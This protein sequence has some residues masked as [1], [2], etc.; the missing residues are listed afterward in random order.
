MAKK[1]HKQGSARRAVQRSTPTPAAI[2]CKARDD[3]AQGRYRDAIAGLKQLLKL[4][5]RPAWRDALAEAYAGRARELADKGMLKESLVMWENRASLGEGISV[6]LDQIA[7]LMRLDQMEAALALYGEPDLSAAQ[8]DRLRPVLAARLLSGDETFARRL[9]ADD[10]VVLHAEAARSALT[11]YCGADDAA[12][13][14]AL[15]AIPFRSP[16]R[17]WAQILKALQRLP[18]RPDESRGLLARVADDSAFGALKRAAELALLPETDF[19]AAIRGAGEVTARFACILRG[20]PEQRIALG[21]ALDR[22][23]ANPSPDHLLHFMARQRAILG[24]DWARRRG[25]RLL[26]DGFPSSMRWLVSVGMGPASKEEEN[27][28][29]A[30]KSESRRELWQEVERWEA[31]ARGLMR[32][33]KAHPGDRKLRIALALRRADAQGDVLAR[34]TPSADADDLDRVVANQVAESLAWDPDDRDAHLRLIHY[35]RRG[36]QLKDARRI[37]DGARTLW[38]N[39]LRVLGASLDI[40]IDAGSFKKATALAREMLAQ[41][42][43]NSGVRERLVNAH[44]AHARKLVLGGRVDL[45][46]KEL[47]RAQEWAGS[48]QAR[49]RLDLTAALIGLA[50]D[51]DAGAP[52]VRALYAKLGGGLDAYLTLALGGDA[53]GLAPQ[54]VLDAIGA[55]KPP[56]SKRD[57]LLAGLSRLRSH[58]DGGAKLS[59]ALGALITN[60]LTGAPWKALSRGETEAACDT[61][62]RCDLHKTRLTVARSA[63]KRWRGAPVFE[64]HLFEA[65]CARG[66][67]GYG[68]TDLDRL[69]RARARAHEEGDTRTAVRIEQILN[70]HSGFGPVDFMD[71]EELDDE[72]GGIVPD[73]GLITM[74]IDT[75]GLDR[76][77]EILGVPRE[78]RGDV[79]RIHAMQGKRAAINAL[80]ACFE[81]ERDFAEPPGPK[82]RRGRKPGRGSAGDQDDDFDDQLDLF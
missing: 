13:Q 22:L 18:Q 58:L 36:N 75:I 70:E 64:L 27:L 48:A 21:E 17:D 47:G 65:K 39:D 4:E 34:A 15:A 5:P 60:A 73:V 72:L 62:R 49:E 55:G 9:P 14:A 31:Y 25:L 19:L 44:L 1:K 29:A 79:K 77:L 78:L 56:A 46:R 7:L 66:R 42:P 41:D 81:M 37:L 82:P 11:A 63:L 76:V 12:L 35:Y 69:E 30:W 45:A 74:L 8:R 28:V 3:L 33:G 61:L 43:I 20:W 59:S 32:E 68:H 50:E 26:I 71:P 6:E 24:E 57:D 40:A 16:Y 52:P 23:G 2:E 54:T 80:A 67:G 53:V 10:P 51:W 38:P